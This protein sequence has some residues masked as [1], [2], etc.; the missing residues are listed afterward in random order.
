MH[1]FNFQIEIFEGL[2]VAGK[3]QHVRMSTPALLHPVRRSWIQITNSTYPQQNN[4]I[5]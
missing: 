5:N 2:G 4:S 1:G 3:N